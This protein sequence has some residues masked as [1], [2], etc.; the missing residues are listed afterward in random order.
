MSESAPGAIDEPNF[1]CIPFAGG[2]MARLSPI[3]GG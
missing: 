2:I 3:G 1:L